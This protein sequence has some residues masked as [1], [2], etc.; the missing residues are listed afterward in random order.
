MHKAAVRRWR[1]LLV[2]LTVAGCGGG[3]ARL[4]HDLEQRFASEGIVR[5]AADLVFRYSHDPGTSNS[6]WEEWPASIVVTRQT[7]YLHQGDRVR[8]EIT[9]R[10]TGEYQVRRERGRISLRAGSGQSAR[11]WAFHPPDDPESW[12]V[13][14]RAVIAGSAGAKRRG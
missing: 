3:T 2:L 1:F 6:G 10:S 7:I 5:R 9:P 8:L 4:S 13:A 12:A 11:S 14:L